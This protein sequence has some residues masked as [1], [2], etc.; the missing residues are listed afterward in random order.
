M[1]SH[2]RKIAVIGMAGR[3]PG[4]DS[5]SALL[6]S[7]KNGTNLI[8]EFTKEELLASG[9]DKTLLDNPH[10]KRFCGYLEGSEYFDNELFSI[11]NR[12]AKLLNPQ[13]RVF[14]ECCW[15]ALENAGYPSF[16]PP[17]LVG[18]YAGS[19]DSEYLHNNLLTDEKIQNECSP[20]ELEIYNS[21]DQLAPH[22]SYYLNLRG[23]SISIQTAC[24]TSLVSIHMACQSI[25][26][27]ESTIALAGGVSIPFIG[28]RGY[29]YKEG[30]NLSVDGRIRSFD[31][32]AS[33]MV[34][35]FGCGVVVLKLLDEAIH[36][37]DYIH[38]VILG[39]AVSN[40]GN[41]KSGYTAPGVQGQIDAITKAIH[42]AKVN[43]NEIQFIEAHGS[44][45]LLGDPIE[46]SALKKAFSLFTS[47][48]QFC[49]VSSIKANIGHLDVA[50]GVAGFIKAVLQLK[51]GMIF[52]ACNFTRHNALINF[53]DSPFYVPT[54]PTELD[55]RRQP[56]I[57]AVNSLGIGGTNC[58]I[59]LQEAA[60]QT[61]KID[62]PVYQFKKNYFYVAPKKIAAANSP[63]TQHTINYLSL[64]KIVRDFWCDV[65][66][67]DVSNEQISFFDL[68]GHSIS[69]L[70]L[71]D[72]LSKSL[73]IQLP[74]S[75]I[76]QF[77]TISDQISELNRMTTQRFSPIIRLKESPNAK[78]H[79][80]I[81][82]HASQSGAE[83]YR[84]MA[85]VLD[86]RLDFLS[87]D[88]IN[89]Q[90]DS[91]FIESIDLL[92][93]TYVDHILYENL[94]SKIYLG[95]WSLGGILAL[96]ASKKLQD[97]GYKIPYVFMLDTIYYSKVSQ[98]FF[99][100]NNYIYFRPDISSAPAYQKLSTRYKEKLSLLSKI[101][102]QMV[103]DYTISAYDGRIMHFIAENPLHSVVPMNDGETSAFRDLKKLNGWPE[104]MIR[105]DTHHI[106]ANHQNI[107][108]GNSIVG[109]ADTISKVILGAS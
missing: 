81:F 74:S 15:S 11:S 65:L 59:L 95:G 17:G 107:L 29:L 53:K 18:V 105:F 31:E 14:L 24:S 83:A 66:E 44:G 3:F 61:E 2:H 87:V 84:E 101:E 26:T 76:H 4:A 60:K 9:V 39:S 36:D 97:K 12:D 88:S 19:S 100:K 10:Y 98:V 57:G 32:K 55:K 27:G 90:K 42:I 38:A 75:W 73:K 104:Q 16:N 41:N 70:I 1:L 23:P 79:Q 67:S 13:H 33:G 51:I 96:E 20:F 91:G 54:T 72:K 71:I 48:Q 34:S 85:E 49:A 93:D 28:K 22:V 58:F 77:P 109:I 102:T 63:S 35:G 40:D 8:Q 62:A 47:A 30:M 50:A 7:L 37:K 6:P 45:T 25:L 69:S 108:T 86:P 99:E 64:S 52:P 21:K 5:I 82:F 80:L 46:I 56:G 78:T 92:V 43:S 89:L 68:G 103:M 94:T 106:Q